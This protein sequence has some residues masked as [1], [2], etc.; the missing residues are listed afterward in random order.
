MIKSR[1]T[2]LCRCT[3]K[4]TLTWVPESWNFPHGERW[5]ESKQETVGLDVGCC[6]FAKDGIWGMGQGVRKLLQYQGVEFGKGFY[7][8]FFN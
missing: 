4:Y 1:A 8:F 7:F 2:T 6:L 3:E 5:W